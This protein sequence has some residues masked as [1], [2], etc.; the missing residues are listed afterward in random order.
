[1]RKIRAHIVGLD[2]K[3]D[4]I[5]NCQKTAEKYVYDG[6][7]F[8][9]GDIKDH[10]PDF[11]PD[12][13]ITLHA[14][15]TATDHALYNAVRWGAK[16]IFSVPCCQHEVNHTVS[17]S[18]AEAL[19]EYG[20]IKERFSALLT[21]TI[22]CKLLEAQGYRVDVLEFIDMEH[23]PK[24]LLIRAKKTNVSA[25]KKEKAKEAVEALLR[26]YPCEQTLYRLLF[27]D[28]K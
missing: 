10:I 3:Q 27:S 4:V 15:D 18:H 17:A 24:N 16:Y 1:M 28:N 7:S 23:S 13:V 12:M 6:L 5:D 25:T 21:D 14:C 19:L 20:L 2:L 11:A 26:E 8:L 22:R 9:C